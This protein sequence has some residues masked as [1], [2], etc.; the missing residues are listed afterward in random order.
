MCV[1]KILPLKQYYRHGSPIWWIEKHYLCAVTRK[2]LAENTI[3]ERRSAHPTMQADTIQVDIWTPAKTFS[4]QYS[5]SVATT[6]T[7]FRP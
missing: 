7:Q 6:S 5:E 3:E 1:P 4:V 2:L